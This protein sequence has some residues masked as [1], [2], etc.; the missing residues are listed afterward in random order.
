M[1][2]KK[3]LTSKII[4]TV[5]FVVGYAFIAFFALLSIALSNMGDYMSK[6]IAALGVFCIPAFVLPMVWVKSRKKFLKG[7][8]I[9]FAA[10]AV[11]VCADVGYHRREASLVINTNPNINIS[12]YLPFDEDSKIVRLENSSLKLT[13]DLPKLDGAAAV[14]PVYSAFVDAVYPSNVTLN[15]D[16]SQKQEPFNYFNTS[17]GYRALGEKSTDIFFGAYPSQEQIEYAESQDT[18][19][20]YIPIGYEGFIFFVN[21][22]CPIESLTTEEIQGIYSGRI[23]NWKELGWV[24]KGIEAYQ[25]NEGSGSQS[26]LKRFMGGIELMEPPKTQINDFMMGIIDKVAD[27]KNHTNAIGFSFRYYFD[28]LVANPNVKMIAVDGVYPS[29]ENIKNGSYPIVT[30]LYAVTYEERQNENV[31]KLI[32]WILSDEGQYI[33][34]ATGYVGVG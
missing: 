10:Y 14:F 4:G 23:T 28:T 32:D 5:L 16:T 24:D 17:A 3:V 26:M 11:A 1:S 13:E 21:K 15:Q 7:F 8:L 20:E 2:K 25:R 19:F 18:H 6:P 31:D 34:E 30:P 9:F 33:I 22:E 27:Y 12:E 29:V